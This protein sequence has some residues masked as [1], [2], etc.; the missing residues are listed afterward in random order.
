MS[1]RYPIGYRND[2]IGYYS[3]GAR[4]AA[5]IL[6]LFDEKPNVLAGAS[7]LDYGC[8]SGRIAVHLADHFANVAGYDPSPTLIMQARKEARAWE[9]KHLAFSA[10][11]TR[12]PGPFDFVVCVLVIEHLDDKARRVALR[13][14]AA[15]L[16]PDGR[17]ILYFPK[18][19]PGG[20]P[21]WWCGTQPELEALL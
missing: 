19:M 16:K 21:Q 20:L 5:K 17:C 13:N 10:L 14:M 4:L 6:A 2:P 18:D 9:H 11:L 3:S 7:L 15:L 1:K 8:G 12:L